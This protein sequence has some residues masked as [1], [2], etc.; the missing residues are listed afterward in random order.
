LWT[1]DEQKRREERAG[2]THKGSRHQETK[3]NEV[4]FEE[5]MPTKNGP[6]HLTTGLATYKP[7]GETPYH[8]HPFSEV[9]IAVRGKLPLRVAGRLYQL[10][11][12]DALHIPC[13]TSFEDIRGNTAHFASN[14]SD[15]QSP[16]LFWALNSTSWDTEF[17][18][19]DEIAQFCP[20]QDEFD[21][22]NCP[23]VF[24]SYEEAK[25]REETP[26]PGCQMRSYFN[27]ANDLGGFRAGHIRL[28]ANSLTPF[29]QN[30][31]ETCIFVLHGRIR[32]DV[33]DKPFELSTEDSLFI[34][35]GYTYQI[36]NTFDSNA[37]FIWICGG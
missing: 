33:N 25:A 2:F 4:V 5:L 23:E 29:I 31:Y 7:K 21:R 15:D 3:Q 12:L 37:E 8:R 30:D 24:A 22:T 28:E 32:C 13:H 16:V 17:L 34:P 6:T 26:L 27:N 9:L 20:V 35:V 18:S 1:L 10:G 36:T 14:P 11:E 19:Q